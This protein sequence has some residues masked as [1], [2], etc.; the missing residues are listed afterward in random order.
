MIDDINDQ[1]K[2][3][4]HGKDKS[5]YENMAQKTID[6]ISGFKSK[7]W[8]TRQAVRYIQDRTGPIEVNWFLR[9]QEKKL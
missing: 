6:K 8:N 5:R 2:R 1:F 4:Y 7:M 9:E 3:T